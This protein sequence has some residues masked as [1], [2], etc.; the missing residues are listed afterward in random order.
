MSEVELR[1]HR[2]IRLSNGTPE[3][4]KRSESRG[5]DEGDGAAYIKSVRRPKSD[6]GGCGLSEVSGRGR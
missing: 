2:I 1:E 4:Q 3:E 5:R 6:G